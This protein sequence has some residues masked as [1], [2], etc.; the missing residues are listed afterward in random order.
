MSYSETPTV[1]A[2]RGPAPDLTTVGRGQRRRVLPVEQGQLLLGRYRPGRQLGGGAFGTVFCAHDERLDR[3]VAVKLLARERVIYERFEREAR[4]AAR[5]QHPAIVTLYE[6]A[7]DDQGAYLVSELVR[8]RTLAQLL[9]AGRLSDHEIIATGIAIA[10]GLD[11]A[12]QMGVIHR[13]V[14]P[15]NI[16]VAS[17]ASTPLARAKLTDFG[18]AQVV[19]G[20][21]LT[22]TGDIVG[23]L[24]YMAPE[25]AAGREA[26][27]ASDLY[28][29]ALVLYE[30][31]CGVNPLCGARGTRI[32]AR[33]RR[34][35]R[36]VPPLRRQR[37]D[38]ARALCA[39]IDTALSPRPEQRGTLTDLRV[40]LGAALDGADETRGVIGAW[41]ERDED[42]L[43][44]PAP[45]PERESRRVER[46]IEGHAR[47]RE[48][49]GWLARAVNG[50]GAA[51]GTVW[52]MHHLLHLMPA[53][54]AVVALV[55]ALLGLALPRLSCLVSAVALGTVGLAGAFPAGVAVLERRWWRR[56][57][58]AGIG[59][60]VLLAVSTGVHHGLYASAPRDSLAGLS[61]VIG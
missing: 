60:L 54:P 58:L 17:R 43:P 21:A 44:G 1:R 20:E 49:P 6:A 38:L 12:H 59:Y 53:P 56:A 9:E 14:K 31:L 5:L 22:R 55:A 35:A 48:L 18:V 30:A 52:L 32:S 37:R 46:R 50:A 45:A 19:G 16:L 24:A 13:D 41:R 4:A 25:Q 29:L 11:H 3:D 57:L 8:G 7:V 51:L 39:G 10:Q 36:F 61:D 2:G 40:A 28:S 23:T 42:P 26:T 33:S 27:P 47:P 34:A 15:S